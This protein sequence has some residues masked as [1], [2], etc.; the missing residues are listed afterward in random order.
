MVT[1][2]VSTFPLAIL[3]NAI[4]FFK[5][6]EVEKRIFKVFF[7][8]LMPWVVF[9]L[10]ILIWSY[11]EIGSLSGIIFNGGDNSLFMQS[12]NGLVGYKG[13]IKDIL[14]FTFL[15]WSPAIWIALIFIISS[16]YTNQ[17]TRL[18]IFVL[19]VVQLLLIIYI[20]P[21]KARHFSGMQYFFIIAFGL[22]A[23]KYTQLNKRLVKFLG[24]L[25][26][27][28]WL[29]M[30]IYYSV[31]FFGIVFGITDE[32]VFY[33]KYIPYYDDFVYL[34]RSLPEKSQFI[35]VGARFNHVH[36]PR[37]V[38]ADISYIDKKLPLYLFYV[39]EDEVLYEHENPIYNPNLLYIKEGDILYGD[40]VF[41]LCNLIY[42]NS[43]AVKYTYRTP[44]KKSAIDKLRVFEICVE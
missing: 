42:E 24:V 43:Q 7:Y 33:K 38:Y 30:Q 18:L 16:K 14:L 8:L 5:V 4:V 23:V 37:R 17:K 2:K 20:L 44:G 28:P 31:P 3:L 10:P 27:V 13:E 26:T 40:E 12:L 34:D 41:K 6:F 9:Y 19:F 39:G 11:T 36:F 15:Y 32:E 22:I 21:N 29:C 25:L 1:S 35:A